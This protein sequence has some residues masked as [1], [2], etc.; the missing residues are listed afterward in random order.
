MCI[1]RCASSSS[2]VLNSEN[3]RSVLADVTNRS[4]LRDVDSEL[5]NVEYD[6]DDD[7]NDVDDIDETSSTGVMSV[8]SSTFSGSGGNVE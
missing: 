4:G 7:V 5:G 3:K 8:T 1:R 6:V 2:M